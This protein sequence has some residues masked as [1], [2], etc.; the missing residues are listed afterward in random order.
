MDQNNYNIKYESNANANGF[1]NGG[2]YNPHI[3]TEEYPS[4]NFINTSY[5]CSNFNIVNYN[6]DTTESYEQPPYTNDQ[7]STN[8]YPILTSPFTPQDEHQNY[9]HQSQNVH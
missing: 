5:N 4:N 3:N 1:S 2:P 8:Q 6:T 9:Y 7:H